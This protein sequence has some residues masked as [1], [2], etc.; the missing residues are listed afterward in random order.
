[1]VVAVALYLGA[2][3]LWPWPLTP[4]LGQALGS[5]YALV[6]TALLVCARSMR[7]PVEAVIP[8]ATLLAWS[9]LLLLLPLLHGVAFSLELGVWIALHVA[10]VTLSAAALRRGAPPRRARSAR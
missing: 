1:M 7:R 8:Y 5:W 10:L 2:V 6:A 4:L 3:E 9:L